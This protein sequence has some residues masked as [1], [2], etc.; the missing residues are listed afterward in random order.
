MGL[1]DHR[2]RIADLVSAPPSQVPEEASYMEDVLADA[3]RVDLFA[4]LARGE[5]WLMWAATQPEF[6]RLFDPSAPSTDCTRAL[7]FWFSE[8]YVMDEDLN[9]V[10]FRVL[11]DAGWRLGPTL[12]WAI[13]QSLHRMAGPR[14]DW[15]GRWLVLLMQNAPEGGSDW[16][17][18]ALLASRWPQDRSVA[19][20]LFDHLTEPQVRAASF[21]G[22]LGGPRFDVRLRGSHHE[23]RDAWQQVFVPNLAEAAASVLAIVDRHLRR[24]FQLLSVAGSASPRWDPISLRRFAIAS[25]SE[26]E[27]Y[28]EAADVLID[29]ARDCVEALLGAGDA[30]AVSYVSGWADSEAPI[31]RRLALHGWRCRTDIDNTAKIAWLRERGWLFEPQLRFEVFRLIQSALPG[32]EA[33]VADALVADALTGPDEA[34]DEEQR[35]YQQYNVLAWIKRHAPDL[36]SGWRAFEHIQARYPQFAERERPDQLLRVE[37][38]FVQPRPPMSVQALHERI[39]ADPAEALATLLA[40]ENARQFSGG[41]TWDDALTLLKNTIREHPADGFAVLDDASGSDHLGIISGVISGWSGASVQAEMAEA[42][43]E[44]LMGLDLAA[45]ADPLSRLLADGGQ[46]DAGPTEWHLFAT[47]RRLAAALWPAVD[48]TPPDTQVTEWLQRAI[49]HPAGR[50]AQFWMHAISA[51]WRMAGDQWTGIP[52]GIRA[53]LEVLLSADDP[54]S[55]LVEVVFASQV[56]FFSGA[57]RRWCEAHV[58]PLLDWANTTR[59][60]RTWDGYLIWGRWTDQLLSAGL[61]DYYQAAAE[62]LDELREDL[63][64]ELASH[65]ATVALFSQLELLPWMRQYTAR[66]EVTQRVEWL[67]HITWLLA[68]LPADGVERQWRRWMQSYWQDRLNSIPRPLATDEASAIAGWAVYL[69]DSIDEGVTLATMRPAGLRMRSSTLRQVTAD[70]IDHAPAQFAKLVAHLLRGTQP[71]FYGC[72]SLA[73]IVAQLRGEA[74]PEHIRTIIEEALRLGCRNAAQW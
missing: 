26:E 47:A 68:D 45:M 74:A 57:D 67:E 4:T 59:A 21:F 29:A 30:L 3:Q 65:L 64:R 39:H 20:L 10:A 56:R 72:D 58:L 48:A 6:R 46:A 11:R 36:E 71:P 61:L 9:S 66:T 70:R 53:Q 18:Y 19:L 40:Y 32:S 35:A 51:D 2:Q 69:T 54:R 73:G 42:I 8:H 60:R 43:L 12:W 55:A 31:L 38:G 44:R 17:E 16:L 50:L 1:L 5:D 34:E 23:L 27:R 7:A 33:W 14:P 62:H 15:L 37:V 22:P 41:P 25:E 52:S 13:G 63:R 24:A 28:S 49:N